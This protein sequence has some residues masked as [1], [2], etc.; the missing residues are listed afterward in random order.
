MYKANSLRF[1]GVKVILKI[2][3]PAVHIVKVDLRKKTIGDSL[4]LDSLLFVT[5]RACH[6]HTAYTVSCVT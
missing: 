2:E 4:L 1:H 6:L 3:E 5:L